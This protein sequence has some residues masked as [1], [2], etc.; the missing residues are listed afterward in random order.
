MRL[1]LVNAG[2]TT[3]EEGFELTFTTVVR[4]E[5]VAPAVLVRR[6][7]GAHVVAPVGDVRLVPGATWEFVATCGHRPGHANDG[8]ES[9]YLR[10]AGGSIRPVR[11]GAT[12][13]VRVARAEA[14]TYRPVNATG[15]WTAVESRDRRLHP[16]D[17]PVLSRTG[18]H[19]VSLDIDSALGP[20]EHIVR[21]D[22]ADLRVS[23]GSDTGLQRALT[24]LVS[25]A[26]SGELRRAG[27]HRPL[28]DWRGLHIDLARQF[29]PAADVAWLID[30]AGWYGLNRLHL[31]LTDDEGWRVPVDG[32]PALTDVG[33]RRGEGLPIPAL[34]GSG[35]E[36]YGGAYERDEIAAWVTAAGEA[37]VVIVPE[38][39]VPGHCFAA[40][41]AYPELADPDD[42]SGAVSVQ[43]FVDNVLNPG[44]PG[45]RPFVEAVFGS[46]AD[47]FPSPWLH[48][49]GDEVP[50]GAWRGSPAARQ[51]AAERG[52]ASSGEIASTF[53]RDL[54]DLVVATTGRRVG[55]WQEAADSGALRP[56][57]GYVVG[58]RSAPDCQRLAAAGFH[59][60][61][62]PAEVYYLDMAADSDWH[63]PG[64][65]WAG[66]SSVTDIEAF[67]VTAGWSAA[68]R[69][70]VLGIQACAWTEHAR[71][72]PTLERLL[73]PRL[74]AI[75]ES[76]WHR[77]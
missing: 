59:V 71:D 14:P 19:P 32:Y 2:P 54:I 66:H 8:P 21:S 51:Y 16:H 77:I 33:A 29:F 47:L 31:H 56:D 20:D 37:G 39:D 34:L 10:T 30:I 27:Q 9:A 68:E 60:V 12:A 74:T 57:D 73:F 44:V 55:A 52:L 24:A 17:S 6:T 61:A 26:R 46:V 67:D 69:G 13:L 58:W 63:T 64:M 5:P 38:I 18:E 28:H 48:I 36:P 35:S 1:R 4:V 62:S 53:V 23:A 43:S 50:H 7:S 72:R 76:A 22:G 11:T 41:S 70:N 42:A 15:A 75:A 3:V 49:G 40:L 45:T 25:G 65:S